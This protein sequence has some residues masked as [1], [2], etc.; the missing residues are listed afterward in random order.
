M[1]WKIYVMKIY[2][3]DWNFN[4]DI[5]KTRLMY[6]NR[7]KSIISANNQLPE[8]VDFLTELGIDIEKPDECNSDFSDVV[9]TC[10]GNAKSED[11]YEIDIYGKEQYISIVV[12]SKDDT[13]ILEV[14]GMK[15]LLIDEFKKAGWDLNLRC[16]CNVLLEIRGFGGYLHYKDTLLRMR[17]N[18]EHGFFDII[19]ENQF[20]ITFR[21]KKCS[22]VWKLG[23]PDYPV[24]GY[25]I[26]SN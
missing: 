20:E 25:F 18:V 24:E 8:L 12:C 7:L 14:F 17:K 16:E 1:N 6:S 3:Y 13:V 23:I 9:Y 22:Q 2:K 15:W 21:C 19:S 11:N 26:R 10:I 4:V 5:Q